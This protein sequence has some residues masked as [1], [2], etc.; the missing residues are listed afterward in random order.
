MKKKTEKKKNGKGGGKDMGD[1][2]HMACQ[3]TEQSGGEEKEP[4][5]RMNNTKKERKGGRQER[6]S[7]K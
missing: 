7:A 2:L 6:V 5:R 3:V 1:S 4:G